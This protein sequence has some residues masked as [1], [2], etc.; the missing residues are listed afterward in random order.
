MRFSFITAVS[1]VALAT[2]TTAACL[3]VKHS[4]DPCAAGNIGDKACGPGADGNV[5]R[6][7]D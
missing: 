4:G 3:G 1:M 6:P 5:V 2:S 7:P